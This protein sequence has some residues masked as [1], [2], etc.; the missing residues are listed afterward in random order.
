LL[1]RFY[2]VLRKHIQLLA[3]SLLM[4]LFAGFM[5]QNK[6]AQTLDWLVFDYA[7]NFSFQSNENELV[8]IE[9]D[10][11]SIAA[12]GRWPWSRSIH[13]KLLDSLL[14]AQSGPVAFDVLFSDVDSVFPEADLAFKASLSSHGRVVLPLHIEKL[15]FQGQVIEMPPAQMFYHASAGI[16]HVHIAQDSDG[17]AR[18]VFL[19]E[20]V[21]KAYW[22]HLS[23][24]LLKL[25]GTTDFTLPG[26]KNTKA[27]SIKM[28]TIERDFLNYIP[29]SGHGSSVRHVS[30]IDVLN[31][32]I[33]SGLLKGKT[34]FVGATA[35]GL[36]D[37]FTTSIG[38]VFGVD[39]N[40]W[41]YIALRDD[42]F[43]QAAPH[44]LSVYL[45]AIFVFV[46]LLFLG[47]LNP[48][49]FFVLGLSSI[50]LLF[51]VSILLQI[52]WRLWLPVIPAVLAVVIFYPFWNWLRLELALGYLRK[53]LKELIDVTNSSSSSTSRSPSS[54]PSNFSYKHS[55]KMYLTSCMDYLQKVGVVDEWI[56]VKSS[57][58]SSI[59]NVSIESETIRLSFGENAV[60]FLLSKS[61]Q[62]LFHGQARREVL[63]KIFAQGLHSQDLFHGEKSR[64]GVELISQT[65]SHI[66]EAKKQALYSQQLIYQGL[67]K[68]SD[69]VIIADVFGR[70]VFVNKAFARLTK[71][72]D[73][74]K[75]N[76]LQVLEGIELESNKNWTEVINLLY[77]GGK[78]MV[79]E[80]RCEL[81]DIDLYFQA[82]LARVYGDVSDTVIISLTDISE[83]RAAE[84]SRME[85]LNFLSHDLRSPMVS[86][87]AIIDL[88]RGAQDGIEEKL[89]PIENLVKKNLDYADSFLQLS[90]AQVVQES[91]FYLVD[92]H[93]VF[94]RTHMHAIA[95][96]KSKSISIETSRVNDDA[97]VM[98]DNDLLERAFIN[99]VSNAIK[100][101]EPGSR[102]SMA[103]GTNNNQCY[104]QVS[105]SGCGIPEEDLGR[106]FERFS[107][108][109]NTGSQSGAGLGLSFV[110]IVIKRHGGDVIVDSKLNQGST[111][112]VN[113]DQKEL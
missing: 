92:L 44:Y 2:S 73:R 12:L 46:F 105:D 27:S 51:V 103:L 89:E 93:S 16:G 56:M 109:K 67:A 24:T 39:L 90:R 71:A 101:S 77:L 28:H 9:I 22:P 62:K 79:G 20:G 33:S 58:K 3:L 50:A 85:A 87:L 36:G 42:T 88:Y 70:I 13:A 17:I 25:T 98:G 86:V 102:V 30:Y 107:R 66:G 55:S 59:P 8:V 35:A 65:V 100:Y 75:K 5:M 68:L 82:R 106:I 40:A 52:V 48:R 45:N 95:L 80:A 1:K 6:L 53:E 91:K 78:F 108:S 110:S 76:L 99:I 26:L 94:D 49:R 57:L 29:L 43:I 61:F 10:D 69:A 37:V 32:D 41:I 38:P 113:L 64:D 72:T 19:K 34:I 18:S 31:G 54:S 97:W 96:A 83:L 14:L 4:A 21:G 74:P 47:K 84:K 81:Y 23:L 111:F 7:Q 60:E 15:G 104:F 112:T 11:K 63:S